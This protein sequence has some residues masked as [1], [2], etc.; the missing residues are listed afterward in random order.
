M[1]KKI[2]TIGSSAG[3]TV[4]PSEL[5]ALGLRIGD[6]VEVKVRGGVLEVAPVNQYAGLDLETLLDLVDRRTAP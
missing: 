5:M 1:R 4:S 6:P 2:V 3:V